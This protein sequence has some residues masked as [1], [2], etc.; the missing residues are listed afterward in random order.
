MSFAPVTA[1][2]ATFT[3]FDNFAAYEAILDGLPLNTQGFEG[4]AP[5]DNLDDVEFLPGI[6][7]TSNLPEVEAFVSG[8]NQK[9]FG[10]GGSVREQGDAFY[11]INFSQPYNAIGFNIEG[12]NPDM[13]GPAIID[14]FF[15]D[16][17]SASIDIFPTNAT[18]SDP[19]FFGV[20][21]DTPI[22]RIRLSEGPE[23]GGF[24]NEEVALDDFVIAL[25]PPGDAGEATLEGIDSDNDG[26]RDDVQR[27]IELTVPDS[28][29]HRE[30]LR[31]V[32]R[33]I[34]RELLAQTKEDSIQAAIAG[35]RA[36]ECLSYLGVRKQNRW[37]E[38]QALMLNTEARLLAMEAH[39]DRITGQV[40]TSLPD[41]L[42][43][44]AC[45]FDVEALPD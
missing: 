28:A 4:F 25:A 20:I 45:T 44:S 10:F 16:Q 42:K 30:A 3:K 17:T 7:V 39:N 22:A 27:Y 35:V 5:G 13:P 24:G 31:S 38:V 12:F 14:I 23:I 32:A 15:V 29:R 41:S 34:Q 37:K 2:A 36:I 8:G 11:D 18:E 9:L 33:V 1:K 6:S 43:R 19:I 40:F 21:A 26:V